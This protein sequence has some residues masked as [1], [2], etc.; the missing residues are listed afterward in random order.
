M[1]VFIHSYIFYYGKKKFKQSIDYITSNRV[2]HLE[3][4]KL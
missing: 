4:Y 2:Y 3:S 1:R